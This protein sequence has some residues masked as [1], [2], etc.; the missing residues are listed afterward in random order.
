MNKR[1][2]IILGA[3]A[4]IAAI[5]LYA[6]RGYLSDVYRYLTK[7]SS[8]YSTDK[9]NKRIGTQTSFS[10]ASIIDEPATYPVNAIVGFDAYQSAG[11]SA[12]ANASDISAAKAGQMQAVVDALSGIGVQTVFAQISW[13]IASD[14]MLR[15][16]RIA[17]VLKPID[18]DTPESNVDAALRTV[19]WLGP[20][21]EK[22]SFTVRA[23]LLNMDFGAATASSGPYG[24]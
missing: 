10:G 13:N 19:A 11:I 24:E 8:Y 14:Q 12:T 7:R 5:C 23:Y 21:M 1:L 3:I 20:L 4:L 9:V 22:M 2:G 17:L 18:S 15:D 6:A 16:F